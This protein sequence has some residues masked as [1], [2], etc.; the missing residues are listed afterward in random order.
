MRPSRRVARLVAL[1]GLPLVL[2][3]FAA[4]GRGTTR[5]RLAGTAYAVPHAYEFSRN[6]HLPWFDALPGLGREPAD[7]LWLML[8]AAVADRVPAYVLARLAAWKRS[9]PAREGVP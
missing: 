2:A 4:Q 9:A 6:V 8:P 7:A 3:A 1:L 5:Y